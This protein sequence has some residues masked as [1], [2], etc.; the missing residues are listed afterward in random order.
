MSKKANG[1]LKYLI[2]FE[3]H[4]KHFS[5]LFYEINPVKKS[6]T[7]YT[8]FRTVVFLVVALLTGN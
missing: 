6:G 3:N 2:A 1:R 5:R 7:L 8:Y 4:E